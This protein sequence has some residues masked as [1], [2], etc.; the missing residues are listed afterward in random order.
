MLRISGRIGRLISDFM[1]ILAGSIRALAC[2]LEVLA[3]FVRSLDFLVPGEIWIVDLIQRDQHRD[4]PITSL[5]ILR[6]LE[7]L[8]LLVQFCFEN[9][10]QVVEDSDATIN[11]VKCEL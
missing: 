7:L 5:T 4:H 8:R 9:V 1:F 6:Y 3:S 10:R 11:L 2:S